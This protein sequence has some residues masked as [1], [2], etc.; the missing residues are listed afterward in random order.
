MSHEAIPPKP[1]AGIIFNKFLHRLAK[2]ITAD[3]LDTLKKVLYGMCNRKKNYKELY[4]K[5]ESVK[6]L[7]IVIIVFK[8][9]SFTYCLMKG[10]CF[11]CRVF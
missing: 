1:P 9:Y 7:F 8:L 11:I 2:S 6:V 10:S 3:Q 4:E 5:I